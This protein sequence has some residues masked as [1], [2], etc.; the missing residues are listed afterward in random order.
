M[1][2]QKICKSCYQ[3]FL[4]LS[5]LPRLCYFVPNILSRTVACKVFEVKG[6]FFIITNK[7]AFTVSVFFPIEYKL[8]TKCKLT[9]V[10]SQ[11]TF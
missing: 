4:V 9:V 10:F 1:H 3:K 2:S 6:F 11:W 5:N 8:R 7:A